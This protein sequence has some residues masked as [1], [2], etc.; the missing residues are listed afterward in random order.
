MEARKDATYTSEASY[1][2]IIADNFESELTY[3]DVPDGKILIVKFFKCCRFEQ[4]TIRI[5]SP[6]MNIQ[7]LIKSGP[8][9]YSPYRVPN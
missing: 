1:N 4:A 9:P 8:D 5:G 2:K 7:N 3:N 6:L